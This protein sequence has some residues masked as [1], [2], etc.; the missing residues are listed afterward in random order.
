MYDYGARFYDPVIGRWTSVD[1]LAEDYEHLTSYN[2]AE[3][4]QILIIYP[5]GMGSDSTQKPKPPPAPIQLK[6][7]KISAFKKTK[8][9][10]AIPGL[11][12]P[13]ITMSQ[14]ARLAAQAEIRLVILKTGY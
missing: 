6:E 7:V 4:N 8:H 3:N 9:A 1:P 10:T 11:T 14:P 2:Y 12:Y 5:D 13:V